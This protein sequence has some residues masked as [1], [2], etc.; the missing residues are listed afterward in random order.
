[1]TMMYRYCWPLL[2]VFTL[3]FTFQRFCFASSDAPTVSLD[4]IVFTA[5]GVEGRISQTAG[6]IGVLD[7]E[8]IHQEQPISISDALRRIPGVSISSDGA[9]GS[10]VNIRGLGRGRVIFLIDGNRVN[11]ATDLNAQFGM[12]DP[13]EIERVEVLKGPSSALYGSG[14]IG[15]VVHVI[16]KKG[17]FTPTPQVHGTL[18]GTYKS[19]PEGYGSYA[20][21]MVNTSL[22]WVYGSGNLR[23]YDS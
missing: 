11:S 1:M 4:G 15:G 5:R 13:A 2:L 12:L 9:W 6:G 23:D 17:D 20:N 19:N 8:E 14:A 21:M 18:T 7:A 16:T 3:L 22:Y 10:E